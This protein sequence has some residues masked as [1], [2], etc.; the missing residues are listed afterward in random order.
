MTVLFKQMTPEA[1]DDGYFYATEVKA[2]AKDIG[3]ETGNL[4]KTELEGL[5]RS[6]LATGV[7]PQAEITSPRKSQQLR[8]DLIAS[9]VVV[10]YV[11]DKRT[12]AFLLSLV[13]AHA[14]GIKAKSGQWYWLNDWRRQQQGRNTRFTYQMLADR[15]MAL[16]QTD[17]RL[18]Q[19]PSARMNNFITD[20]QA[21]SA[22]AGVPRADI[23]RAWEA[24]KRHPGPKTYAAYSA[25]PKPS[26]ED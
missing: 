14:P 13:E 16:M 3:I 2:F 21:D 25:R 15:L 5:I 24:V 18:P 4:R 10:N 20:F 19:I 12:K 22:N 8:D 9:T 26:G 11:G 1:F 17:G 23:M 7:V 6:F